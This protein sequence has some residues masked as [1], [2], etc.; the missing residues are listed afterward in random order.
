MVVWPKTRPVLAQV[1][2]KGPATTVRIEGSNRAPKWISPDLNTHRCGL[3]AVTRVQDKKGVRANADN[4]WEH[5]DPGT[6]DGCAG[7]ATPATKHKLP[8]VLSDSRIAAQGPNRMC[9][10]PMTRCKTYLQSI[11]TPRRSSIFI[12]T[13]SCNWHIVRRM[14]RL[15]LTTWNDQSRMH[16]ASGGSEAPQTTDSSRKR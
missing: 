4:G 15:T 3:L 16:C 14:Q 8:P 5:V 6:I 2:H 12:Q 13:W 7:Q 11:A 1:M 10:K 9:V